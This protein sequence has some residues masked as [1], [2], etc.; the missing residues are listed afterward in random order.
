[1]TKAVS[2]PFQASETVP[3]WKNQ[4]GGFGALQAPATIRPR[5]TKGL[6]L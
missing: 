4:Y 1:M 2:S 5:E 3:E 6:E